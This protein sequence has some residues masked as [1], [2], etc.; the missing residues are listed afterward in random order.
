VEGW[1]NEIIIKRPVIMRGEE[2]GRRRGR[3]KGRGR[4]RTQKGREGGYRR[5]ELEE[6]AG[7]RARGESQWGRGVPKNK[8]KNGPHPFGNFLAK[9]F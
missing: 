1:P 3:G 5:G 2:I 6:G 7:V 9:G 4:R 8:D